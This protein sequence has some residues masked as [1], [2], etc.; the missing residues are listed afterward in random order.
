MQKERRFIPKIIDA[1]KTLGR[2]LPASMEAE[3]SVLAALLLNDENIPIASEVI[4]AHDFYHIPHKVI[5]QAILDISQANKRLDIITLQDELLKKNQLETAG[6]VVYLVSLQEDLPAIGFVE[7]HARIVKSKAMLRELIGSAAHIIA[8]CY[9]QNEQ[10]ID[11]VLD[12]AEKVI[13]QIS[14]KRSTQSFVQLNIWLKK[15][16]KHLSE[17]KSHSKGITGI[18]AGYKKLDQLTSGFQKSDFIVLAARPSMGKTA[19]ALSIASQAANENNAVGFF[20]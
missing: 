13:F 3:R 1:E 11:T 20:L 10:S 7:Q 9:D 4:S 2:S 12:E 19:L 16:F 14:N 17:L 5:Y 8:N 15:T 18:P 6:G